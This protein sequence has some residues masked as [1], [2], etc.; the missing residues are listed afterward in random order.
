MMQALTIPLLRSEDQ[1]P[2]SCELLQVAHVYAW[3]PGPFMQLPIA[4]TVLSPVEASINEPVH[5]ARYQQ[6]LWHWSCSVDAARNS[7]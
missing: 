7:E 2:C 6:S 4:L 3:K 5:G 1:P